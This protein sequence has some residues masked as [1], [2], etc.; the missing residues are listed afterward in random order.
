M[1][2]Q[3]R[4]TLGKKAIVEFLTAHHGPVTAE[5]LRLALRQK[6]LAV[7]RTTVYRQL[8]ALVTIGQATVTRFADGIARYEIPH[9]H[10]HHVVCRSC[11]RVDVVSL[12]EHLQKEEMRIAATR[13]YT[14]ITHALEFFGTC[15]Q[16][17]PQH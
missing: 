1:P 14:N 6:G 10:H 12:H 7:H 5:E 9:E 8:D 2:I 11:K 15:S 3:Q 13:K 16:C 17:V 4:Q